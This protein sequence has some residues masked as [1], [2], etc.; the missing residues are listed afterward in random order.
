MTRTPD[1]VETISPIIFDFIR[2]L[3]IYY[4]GTFEDNGA[5][6]QLDQTHNILS[7]VGYD[8]DC[9]GIT[10]KELKTIVNRVREIIEVQEIILKHEIQINVKNCIETFYRI[11][12]FCPNKEP[13]FILIQEKEKKNIQE[14]YFNLKINVPKN[15]FNINTRI[16]PIGEENINFFD[17]LKKYVDQEMEKC[18]D[19]FITKKTFDGFEQSADKD[20]RKD[21]YLIYG[22]DG[23]G[24]EYFAEQ[25]LI[26]NF[27]KDEKIILKANKD[28]TIFEL[29]LAN[30]I[31]SNTNKKPNDDKTLT[32]N[33]KT[34][35]KNTYLKENIFK[36]YGL[37]I[38][39]IDCLLDENGNFKKGADL[40]AIQY[41]YKLPISQ[42]IKNKEK[43]FNNFPTIILTAK[44]KLNLNDLP[45][46]YYSFH[47]LSF[48][49]WL[50]YYQ[51]EKI[52]LSD[53]DK[54]LLKIIHE[55]NDG[56][57]V[58]LKYYVEKSKNKN[59]KSLEKYLH[60]DLLKDKIKS[61]DTILNFI[62]QYK[63]R[64]Y[65][66]PEPLQTI[67]KNEL[68]ILGKDTISY[69]LLC[70]MSLLY[71]YQVPLSIV[72]QTL[73]YNF[74]SELTDESD[75]DKDKYIENLEN[76]CLIKKENDCYSLPFFIGREAKSKFTDSLERK[77][78]TTKLAEYLE[79]K[80]DNIPDTNQLTEND[81]QIVFTAFDCYCEIKK[82]KDAWQLLTKDFKTLDDQLLDKKLFIY[83]R[84]YGL[85][86]K[87]IEC[88]EQCQN[89]LDENN[90]D[91]LYN[92]GVIGL[93]CYYKN[94][95]DSGISKLEELISLVLK[96]KENY[97]NNFDCKEYIRIY[98]Y[99]LII[100]S[101]C[102][103][104]NCQ[105]DRAKQEL[106]KI[107]K[108]CKS[109][110]KHIEIIKP[111][112]LINADKLEKEFYYFKIN[113]CI[114]SA[115][116]ELELDNYKNSLKYS[117]IGLKLLDEAEEK[118]IYLPILKAKILSLIGRSKCKLTV[119][120]RIGDFG[121]EEMKNAIDLF[122]ENLDPHSVTICYVF[123]MQIYKETNNDEYQSI[124]KKYESIDEQYKSPLIR[125]LYAEIQGDL[126]TDD[127]KKINFYDEAIRE[128]KKSKG[129]KINLFLYK[130]YYKYANYCFER[131]EK[132]NDQELLTKA[133]YY[134]Q[135]SY[136]A[137][138][139]L[140]HKEM[141]QKI[142]NLY[143]NIKLEL[144]KK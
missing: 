79:D 112:D 8:D 99:A 73:L 122:N 134:V 130:L 131:W 82:Y 26:N 102:Y 32:P 44:Q 38:S 59:F 97:R 53:I 137:F 118:K 42:E 107:K 80:Y 69:K 70:R 93:C 68:D 56:S 21:I 89:Q 65:L 19:L 60:D 85:S 120:N 35:L 96:N 123:L 109:L 142:E 27:C 78:H 125:A 141:S 16:L 98:P 15:I 144:A 128:V 143:K 71:T 66:I 37:L 83:A 115:K 23:S 34:R 113:Y 1:T 77:E 17:N 50:N 49:D 18:F 138:N 75:P 52:K 6:L 29:L 114:N 84:R 108:Y 54:K 87:L 91:S 117:S 81:L 41:L 105:T 51:K 74:I 9:L 22:L 7:T 31:K 90:F 127:N 10:N 33:E 61:G 140:K 95:F 13:F 43:K 40:V 92:Q 72:D 86:D 119:K 116:I 76:R 121:E 47:G 135:E 57:F 20:K 106:K 14:K 100:L 124:N 111:N 133:N 3:I 55:V 36:E 45:I 30:K 101:L 12:K 4:Q 103:F 63:N 94:K 28:Q 62:D 5:L 39:N 129:A 132:N 2:M 48:Q 67:I 58:A 64:G 136:K 25:Y 11:R 24:K 139:N 126:G 104:Y 88:Y 46:Y 110:Q